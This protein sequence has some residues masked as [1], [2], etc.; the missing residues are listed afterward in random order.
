MVR[1]PVKPLSDATFIVEAEVRQ[2]DGEPRGY[3]I[4][5]VHTVS[6]SCE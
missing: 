4:T 3:V 1:G 5:H 2:V 6:D